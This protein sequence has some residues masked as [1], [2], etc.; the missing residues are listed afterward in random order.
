M[1]PRDP[2]SPDANMCSAQATKQSRGQDAWILRWAD[3]QTHA[4][5]LSLLSCVQFY[6]YVAMSR[7]LESSRS[8]FSPLE[9]G[10]SSNPPLKFES[11]KAVYINK[12]LSEA[13]QT[14]LS[15]M[16]VR[17][18]YAQVCMVDTEMPCLMVSPPYFF[19]DRVSP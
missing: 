6:G 12:A 17:V 18:S 9:N 8:L 3:A 5:N 14:S 13:S 10:S 7:L 1:S 2:V 15:H 16:C 4:R 11:D 19:G